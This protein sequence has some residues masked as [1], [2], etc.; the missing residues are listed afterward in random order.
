MDAVLS[1]RAALG[2]G[3]LGAAA[4]AAG[5]A[6]RADAAGDAVPG[7]LPDIT[8]AAP[9]PEQVGGAIG[10]AYGQVARLS[11]HMRRIIGVFPPDPCDVL[12][13]IRNLQGD[14]LAQRV[15]TDV[16]ANR[17]GLV[18]FTHSASLLALG[19]AFSGRIQLVAEVEHT[20]GYTIGASLEIINAN[21]GQTVTNVSPCIIPAPIPGT[22][23]GT[24]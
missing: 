9:V 16:Q 3:G 7:D 1:R 6:A 21:N 12:I 10:I 5:A 23:S 4:L 20:R 8:A 11:F 19:A 17:G 2:L 22:V 18:D 24:G 13:R 15:F 14:V